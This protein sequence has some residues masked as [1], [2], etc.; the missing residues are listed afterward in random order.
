[1]GGCGKDLSAAHFQP[2][3]VTEGRRSN[4]HNHTHTERINPSKSERF[5]PGTC[6]QVGT[7]WRLNRP[8]VGSVFGVM[9]PF[10]SRRGGEQDPVR[11]AM[12]LKIR[13]CDGPGNA[14]C[15]SREGGRESLI[16]ILNEMCTYFV[17][18]PSLFLIPPLPRTPHCRRI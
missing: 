1:M 13:C 5:L 7:R 4:T 10:L 15:L 2:P 14:V 8:Q 9:W 11:P 3:K 18:P 12:L 6:V 17:I 16:H